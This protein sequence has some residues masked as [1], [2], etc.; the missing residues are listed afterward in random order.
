MYQHVL[1]NNGNEE[2]EVSRQ[3]QS[4]NKNITYQ[5]ACDILTP[6]RRHF[7]EK[8]I[9]EQLLHKIPHL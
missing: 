1:R 3:P 2:Q 7:L 8:P 9:V 5:Q 6:R 4:E